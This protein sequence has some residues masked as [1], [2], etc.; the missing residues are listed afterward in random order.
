MSAYL[1]AGWLAF[2]ALFQGL[3]P[4][5]PGVNFQGETYPV[6]DSCL[7]FLTDLT[8]QDSLGETQHQQEIFDTV[9]AYIESAEQYI[10]LDMFLFNSY[11][12][13]S[14]WSL[15]ELS[16][17]LSGLLISKKQRNPK[18]KIDFITDPVNT[19]YG[20]V[21]H[22]ELDAMGKAGINVIV[23]DLT[24]LRDSNPL[25][26]PIWRTLFQWF[27]NTYSYGLMPNA[28]GENQQPVTLRSYLAFLN[29]KANHRKVF[30][31]DYHNEMV[32]I[33]TSANPHS[34]SADFSN[35]GILVKGN[36]WQDLYSTEQGVAGFSDS[37]LSGATIEHLFETPQKVVARNS[38]QLISEGKIYEALNLH[39]RE[40]TQ[41]DTVKIAMFYL[42]NR[43]IV[44]SL[45]KASEQGAYI[46]LILDPNKDG[47]GFHHNGTPN[48]PT[49][50]E[51]RKKSDNRIKIRWYNT[52][53]EQFHSKLTFIKKRGGP[54]IVILGSSNLT[55]KNLENYNLETDVLL[56]LD[57]TS[58]V[59][60][61]M[62][63][64]F[65]RLWLNQGAE[66]TLE[67]AVYDNAGTLKTLLYRFQEFTGLS[68]Y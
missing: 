63:A 38:I 36:L 28:F 26:S 66:F 6:A 12:G 51:L 8:F 52:Q 24:R 20:G 40:T 3:K 55:R 19:L 10:L 61:E 57:P 14:N 9:F 30:V 54:N 56:T 64:Y 67:H 47:F 42:S 1:I 25:Y 50:H 37:Q 11:K 22:P 58:S 2:V 59:S 49:A 45:L 53:G 27:G 4:L 46:Q 5:P 32:S 31:A 62:E 44:K 68:T 23:S 15:N 43:K 48:R 41:G 16:A 17:D 7:E 34:A 60:A 65:T 29:L 35:I 18:L 21:L 13:P 39:L 33:V